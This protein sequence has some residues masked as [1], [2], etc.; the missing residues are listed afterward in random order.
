MT[1]AEKLATQ[2][3][4]RVLAGGEVAPP[5]D[6]VELRQ[7]L[8]AQRRRAELLGVERLRRL[9]RHLP[10][11]VGDRPE[12]AAAVVLVWIATRSRSARLISGLSLLLVN[13][14][15]VYLLMLLLDFYVYTQRPGDRM[16]GLQSTQHLFMLDDGV[17]GLNAHLEDLGDLLFGGDYSVRLGSTSGSCRH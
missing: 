10:S 2:K 11:A 15:A 6:L 7:V 13:C 16:R 12:R 1:R 4:S 5:Q 9:G 14:V 17:S 3:E 8:P